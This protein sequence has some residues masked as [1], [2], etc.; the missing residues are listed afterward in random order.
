M[1]TI[2]LHFSESIAE[3]L[4]DFLKTFSEKDL[5]I[6]F[7]NDTQFLAA[8]KELQKDY[9]LYKNNKNPLISVDDA[10]EEMNALF[11]SNEN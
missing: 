10:E 5:K 8:K 1:K 3:K 6:E 9:D 11:Q 2:T 4:N 7:G